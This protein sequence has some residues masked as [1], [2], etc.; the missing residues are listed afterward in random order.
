MPAKLLDNFSAISSDWFWET[1]ES[2]RL[3]YLSAGAEGVLGQ[4]VEALI[5]RSREAIASNTADE[6]FWRPYRDAVASRREFRDFDYPYDHPDGGTRWFKVSGEPRFST[7]GIFLGFRGVCSDVTE[8]RRTRDALAAALR[9]LQQSNEELG[10]QLHRFDAALANMTQGLCMF[11]AASRLVVC[12]ARYREIF[13]LTAG[14]IRSGM[15]QWEIC[16]VLV[17]QGT[18]RKD[19][20][21]DSLCE[22]TRLALADVLGVPSHR[23]LADGRVI[24]I[25][26]RRMDG[27]GWVS[28]FEDIT[29]RRRNE[30]RIAHMARHDGLTDL[31][32]RTA[33]REKGLEMLGRGREDAGPGVALLCLDLDRFKAVNDM[34]GHAVG[35]ELLRAV[36]ERLRVNVREGDVIGRLGGDEFAVLHR[37]S[38]EGGALALAH[39]L[40]RALS[41]SYEINGM[42]LDIGTSVGVAMA[43]GEA[44][45]IERLLKNA[46][47]ALYHAKG[48]GRGTASVFVAAMDENA[49]ARRVLERELREAL[50]AGNFEL[51]YQPLVDLRR[52]RVTGLEALVRW[53]HPEKGLISPATFIPLAEETGLIVPLGEWVLSQACR[54]AAAWPEDI[55]IAV[56]VSAVQLRQRNF[57][58]TVL[59]VLSAAWM[60]PE[61]LELEITESVLLDDTESNL[62]TL[63]LLR[64]TGIRIS[65][66]DFGTGY[67]SLSYLR[68]FPF[69]KIKIDR[70]FVR[71]AEK[72]SDA[73]AILKAL[74]GL[75]GNLGITTLV[76]GIETEAQL[77]S[78]RAEGCEQ[79]QGFL[80]SPPRPASEIAA[81]LDSELAAAA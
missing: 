37:V 23:E 41:A 39:R 16:E 25:I 10:E 5:G 76:E 4:P 22:G 72:R 81:L 44:D 67:S 18:Y 1:D 75:G 60:R 69:D 3:V 55:T 31:P 26:Y 13:G 33:L 45:D 51:H 20:T 52:G 57:A 40:V 14:A 8:H 12:N 78:I 42:M 35:D 74:V 77:A 43:T 70:S 29:E 21:V 64:R 24:A 38:D 58:Q 49:K 63:H 56:N 50:V 62:E 7:E 11:D 19:V 36:A 30:A 28:T 46:D 6:T 17:G 54:D 32:N 66:D 48:A 15:T 59:T 47:V 2:S 34:Y 27:G 71:D 79:M 80:F 9:D 61:R 53:R 68:R 73:G 65:M